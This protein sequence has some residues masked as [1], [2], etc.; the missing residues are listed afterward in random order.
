MVSAQRLSLQPGQKARHTFRVARALQIDLSLAS[1][2]VRA[3]TLNISVGGFAALLAGA[4]PVAE[5]VGFKLKTPGSSEPM[6]GR[7]KVV[8]VQKRPGNALV[9]FQFEALSATDFDKLDRIVLDIALEQF[10]SL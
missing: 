6:L 3:M 4:P 8:E 2:G 10:S 9:S 7:C 5:A 1:G